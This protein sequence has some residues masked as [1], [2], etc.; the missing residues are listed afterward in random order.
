MQ[1]KLTD[2]IIGERQRLDLGDLTDLDSM[3]EKDVGL[4]QPI[5]VHKTLAGYE[6]V[7]GR[8]RLAKATELGWPTIEAFEKDQLTEIQKNKMEFFADIARKDRTWQE[9]CLAVRKIHYMMEA[10]RSAQG[11]K[12]TTRTMASFTG[13][14]QTSIKYMLQVAAG[15]SVTPKDDEIWGASSY[16]DAIKILLSRREADARA[17]LEKR[18][19]GQVPSLNVPSSEPGQLLTEFEQE[20][21]SSVPSAPST[22]HPAALYIHGYNIAF[23][24]AEAEELLGSRHCYPLALAFRPSNDA[25]DLTERMVKKDGTMLWWGVDEGPLIWNTIKPGVGKA[26]WTDT[27]IYGD[28]LIG[29]DFPGCSSPRGNVISAIQ[30][31]DPDELPMPVVDFSTHFLF[32]NAAVLCV[33]N[34]PVLSLLELGFTPVWFEADK[35]KFDI[36]CQQIRDHYERNLPGIPVKLITD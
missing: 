26:P 15:L 24:L 19:Q 9:K 36:K 28:F 13:I 7:D 14:G 11:D 6:L 2:I 34:A 29:P 5:L 23:E 17:E 32:E 21:S 4:I 30:S 12:W 27:T 1:L 25:L 22:R 20:V 18:R 8:R 35:A 3:S 31:A 10:E 33:N 16:V